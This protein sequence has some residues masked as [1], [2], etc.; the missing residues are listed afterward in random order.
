MN[1]ATIF[2]FP[3]LF[4]TYVSFSQISTEFRYSLGNSVLL[5]DLESS[6]KLSHRVGLSISKNRLLL[7]GGYQKMNHQFNGEL[8]NLNDVNKNFQSELDLLYVSF[9]RKSTLVADKLFIKLGLDFGVG[10]HNNYGN[11]ENRAGIFYSDLFIDSFDSPIYNSDGDFETDLERYNIDQLD[12]YNTTFYHFGPSVSLSYKV[13]DNLSLNLTSIYR[14]NTTDLLDNVNS[15]NIRGIE[16][17]VHNDDHLDFFVGLSFH[18]NY[19]KKEEKNI[20]EKIEEIVF[21]DTITPIKQQDNVENIT[22]NKEEYIL[23]FFDIDDNDEVI[24][25]SYVEEQYIEEEP[26]DKNVEVSI[27]QLSVNT[28]KQAGYYLVVGVFQDVKNA[29]QMALE[30]NIDSNNTIFRNELHYLYVITSLELKEV[31]QLRENI[32]FDSWILTVTD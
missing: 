20:H 27:D 18:L 24:E 7:E 11:L 19:K 10:F 28:Q 2:I 17:N 12:D 3:L 32:N 4:F 26:S 1:R 22:V 9:K 5:Y 15:K 25:N 29:Q 23:N 13:A 21:Q 6:S 31:R 30:L 14:K 8:N 16:T